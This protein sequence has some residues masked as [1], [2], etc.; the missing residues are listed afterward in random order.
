[1]KETPGYMQDPFWRGGAGGGLWEKQPPLHND[2]RHPLKGPP[3]SS[4]SRGGAR[5]L[6]RP[7]KISP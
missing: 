6:E 2:A 7:D 1:M 3:V 4:F 5:N